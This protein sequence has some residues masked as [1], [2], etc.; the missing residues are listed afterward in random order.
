MTPPV[1]SHGDLRLYLLTLL[2]DG[3]RHG[4]G[5]IQ[6]LSERTGGTYTPSAGTVYPRLAKLEAEGLVIKTADGRTV[7]YEIT[8]AGR[9]EVAARRH[10][11]DGIQAR[12]A[13]SVRLIAN[14]V[15][16]N[17]R[18]AM[19][20]LRADLAS[21]ASAPDVSSPAESSRAP[22]EPSATSPKMRSRE[23]LHRADA[24][25]NEFRARIRTHLR[26]H[27]AS[28][29]EVTASTIDIL[30][31]ALTATTEEVERALR[32]SLRV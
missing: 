17:V 31:A 15:R 20:S 12:L 7:T 4:Y 16:G 30:E 1:F 6:D 25:V 29:G 22:G 27:A 23:Q 19:K 5:I 9:A 10:E 14:E 21:A 28:G 3:P 26:T 2:D 24:V 32:E 11:F 8:E 13:D 18:E